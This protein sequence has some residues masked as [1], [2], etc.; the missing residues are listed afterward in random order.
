MGT[1]MENLG[2]RKAELTNMVEL[3]GR[4]FIYKMGLRNNEWIGMERPTPR[5][6]IWG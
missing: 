2:Q 5:T 6:S 3:T 4:I 1:V